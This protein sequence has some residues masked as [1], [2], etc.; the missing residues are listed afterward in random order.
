MEYIDDAT[1][2]PGSYSIDSSAL[3]LKQKTKV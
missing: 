3:N 2:G 1:P